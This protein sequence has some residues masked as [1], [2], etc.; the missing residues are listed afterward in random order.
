MIEEYSIFVRDFRP[1]Q[2]NF[3]C[4]ND[5]SLVATEHLVIIYKISA[6]IW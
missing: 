1:I 2:T 5:L 3:K 4:A 6:K